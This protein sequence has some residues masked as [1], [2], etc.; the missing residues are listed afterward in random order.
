M[1]KYL[2]FLQH[3]EE[4]ILN[5]IKQIVEMESPTSNKALNDKLADTLKDIFEQ[6]TGGKAEII[7]DQQYGNHLKGYF[8]KGEEQILLVGHFDTV[9]PVGLLKRNPFKIEDGKAYG[10]GIY[11]MKTGLVQIIYALAAIKQ[12]GIDFNKRVVCLFNSD[13]EMGS[14]NSRQLLID[15]AKKS[16]YAFVLEPSFGEQGAIK[17]ARKGVGSYKMTVSGKTAHAG[18]CPEQGENAIEEISHQVLNLQSLNDYEA[19]ITVNCGMI[20]GGSAKN[21]VPD[22][23]ELMIDARVSTVEESEKIHEHISNLK[24]QNP[25]TEIKVEGGFTRPPMEKN[26]ESDRLYRL[27]KELMSKHCNLPLPEAFVGGAS[28]GNITSSLIPTLDGLG[29]VGGGAHSLDEHIYTSHLLPR[30]AL[31]AALLEYC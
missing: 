15:E 4:N 14:V 1:K 3:E 2:N 21:T 29:A 24:P 23:A 8:G 9:H 17:T 31:L 5:M 10:P 12:S 26:D 19:G 28:D 18:L 27:A 30:T 16:K 6:Y 20:N 13:E 11:D 22:Y 7:E 25:H